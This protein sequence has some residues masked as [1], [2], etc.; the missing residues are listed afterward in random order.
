PARR[1]ISQPRPAPTATPAMNSLDSLSACPM[2]DMPPVPGLPPSPPSAVAGLLDARASPSLR[3]RRSTS[4][5]SPPSVRSA[6]R[7]A[8]SGEG[9]PGSP[10]LFEPAIAPSCPDNRLRLSA[11]KVARN[12]VRPPNPV[13]PGPAQGG[14][15]NRQTNSMIYVESAARGGNGR[16]G[17]PRFPA[18]RRAGWCLAPAAAMRP[19]EDVEAD[20]LH[21]LHGARPARMDV[22]GVV[23]RGRA[24][25]GDKDLAGRHRHRHFLGHAVVALAA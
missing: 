22:G 9:S 15:F 19:V 18:K 6:I 10:G 5:R 4:S 11:S 24:D 23:V 3:L 1:S 21:L 25:L 20:L 8:M 12:I 2:P 16:A 13:K 7:S 17:F 14:E